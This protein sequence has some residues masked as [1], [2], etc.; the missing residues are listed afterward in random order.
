MKKFLQN[1]IMTMNYTYDS[2]ID[3]SAG[4][5]IEQ[6]KSKINNAAIVPMCI[7]IVSV[8]NSDIIICFDIALSTAEKT[9]LDNLVAAHIPVYIENELDQHIEDFTNP[10][11]VTKTQ[12]GLPDVE[13]LKV[14]LNASTNPTITDDSGSG[15]VVGSRWI[16]IT[17]DKEYVCVDAS[18]GAA[19]WIETTGG[20]S[21]ETNTMSNIGTGGVGIFKQVTGV[22]FEM[23][24]INVGSNKI[25]V[26]DDTANNEIDIDVN[27]ANIVHQNLSGAGTNTHG[28]IDAH[29]ASTAN[30]HSVTKTQVGLSEVENL[31]VNLNASTAPGTSDDGTAGYSIGSRWI[32]T[33]T[34]LEYVCID[35]TNG[36]A[37]WKITTEAVRLYDAIVD[38]NGSGDFTNIA[39]AFAVGNKTVY[40]R[41]GVYPESSNIIIPSDG[42][43]VGEVLDGT[44]IE[45]AGGQNITIGTASAIENSGTIS[46]TH[47][48]NTVNGTGTT[49]TNLSAGN[50][51][52]LEYKYY[53]IANIINDT[54]IILSNSYR[55]N[56][57]SNIAYNAQSL[58]LG[59]IIKNITIKNT[60]NTAIV[61]NSTKTLILD[62]IKV[63]NTNTALTLI[64]CGEISIYN[65]KFDNATTNAITI[66]TSFGINIFNSLVCN[67][68]TAGLI[69]A[70]DTKTVKISNCE[71]LNNG[72]NGI[73]MTGTGANVSIT[74]SIIVRNNGK[75]V[76]TEQGTGNMNISNCEI[77]YNGA[78][79]IDFDGSANALI[80]CIL[81]GNGNHGVQA[82]DNGTII[83]NTI[84]NNG[85]NGVN[86]TIDDEC[87]T[88][89]NEIIGNVVGVLSNGTNHTISNN[90]IKNNNSFGIQLDAANDN[91]INGNNI[92]G[93]TDDGINING[94]SLR[95][96]IT[97]NIINTNAIGIN[98]SGEH[99]TICANSLTTNSSNGIS[100][101]GDN[102]IVTNNKSINNVGIGCI[103]NSVANTTA[104]N[105]IFTNNTG[106]NFIDNGSATG[107]GT[108]FIQ[109]IS[110]TSTSITTSNILQTKLL[111]TTVALPS[112]TY[113]LSW[114]I[115][116]SAAAANDRCFVVIDQNNAIQ[117]NETAMRGNVSAPVTNTG[118]IYLT[119]LSGVNEFR[120]KYRARVAGAD[121]VSVKNA[122]LELWKI[123]P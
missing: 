51:I 39:D 90:I 105:N 97:S 33:L 7:D 73:D 95:T 110:D 108:L 107:I 44:I 85:A 55:G 6:F 114:S 65:S 40:V 32:D 119:G 53:E 54:T 106:G 98:T 36:A 24:N 59:V 42:Q 28:Q 89:N 48:T 122:R 83:G 74:N 20:G 49:F 4:V 18:V 66:T 71:I 25:T 120:I 31:K 47:D 92:F 43:L 117:L 27:E 26:T 41:K 80:N 14:N 64:N 15:Y 111:M 100:I 69:I 5:H 10:H 23:K 88:S 81:M 99:T 9:I 1:S 84:S 68:N 56:T 109:Q 87:T 60:T 86:M 2:I 12:V 96:V 78:D 30:P 62:S 16:D 102:C 11:M 82:G 112:N 63:A 8:N 52:L 72:T 70:G 61:V 76:N 121:T 91:I 45:F 79:G 50:F 57:L 35:A 115:E 118:F 38:I 93:N 94:M 101:N 19:I 13:N 58:T 46:I 67:S 75:G 17:N 123:S 77:S 3:F 103:I 37:A 113:R 21:G 116:M 34:N 104:S 22:N 29:I